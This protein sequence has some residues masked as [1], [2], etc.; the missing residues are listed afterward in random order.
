MER[1]YGA[2][3]DVFAH[4]PLPTGHSLSKL[5]NVVLTPHVAAWTQEV[6]ADMGWLGARN[7]WQMLNGEQPESLVNPEALEHTPRARS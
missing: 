6:L 2:G 3:L 7:L 1:I 5:S 4:E